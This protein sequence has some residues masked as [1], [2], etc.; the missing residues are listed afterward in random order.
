MRALL[1][2]RQTEHRRAHVRREEH[3]D[4]QKHVDPAEVLDG[5]GGSTLALCPK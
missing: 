3:D 5:H 1:A 2:G 4:A